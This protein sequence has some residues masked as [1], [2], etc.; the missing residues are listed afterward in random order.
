VIQILELEPGAKQAL[1]ISMHLAQAYTD[2]RKMIH[3]EEAI[4]AAETK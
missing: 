2:S 4:K 1:P 3:S